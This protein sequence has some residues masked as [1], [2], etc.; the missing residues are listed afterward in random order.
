MSDQT[1]NQARPGVGAP[2]LLGAAGALTGTLVAPVKKGY[3]SVEELLSMAP[4]KFERV[5]KEFETVKAAGLEEG[6]KLEGLF[7]KLKE[8]RE[9]VAA[10]GENA[11]AKIKEL[12]SE[13]GALKDVTKKD[14][15]EILP[16]AKGW[17]AA[18]LAIVGLLIGRIISVN[19]ANKKNAALAQQQAQQA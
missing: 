12:V 7:T 17:W 11:A 5:A 9:A 8:G 10:A 1:V 2:I 19:K 16:K 18:G 13:G 15:K 6:S 14:L 4:D 3:R